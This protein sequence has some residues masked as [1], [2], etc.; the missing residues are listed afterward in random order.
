MRVGIA[1]RTEMLLETASRLLGTHHEI[2]FLATAA[3]AE[4][5]T[6]D[7]RSYE[8]FA[9]DHGIPFINDARLSKRRDELAADVCLS[10]NWPSVL[11]QAFLDHFPLGVLNAHAGDLPRYRGNAT[12]NWAILRG[13]PRAWLSIH[14]MVPELDAGP[15][16]LKVSR[17]IEAD[18]DITELYAW[19]AEAIPDSFLRV[20]EQ[21]DA[22]T[23]VF[24]PQ[25]ESVTPFRAFPRRPEDSR[26]DWSAPRDQILRL[27]RASSRPFSGALTTLEGTREVAVFRAAAFEPG[28]EFAAVPGQVCFANEGNPVIATG[29]GL[30]ELLDCGDDETRAA[31]L[32]SL[33]NRLR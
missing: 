4:Y 32:S 3:A 33:R 6:A 20:V 16:A 21:L 13:E 31:I 25:S 15:I 1:G 18:T 9:R 29:D 8:A 27:V 23:A 2:A 26:I 7:E 19:L 24:E 30:I 11:P 12:L 10:M 5:S 22:G 17:P 14:R 28:Y